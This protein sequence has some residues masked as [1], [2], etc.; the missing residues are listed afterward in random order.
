MAST[1]HTVFA[2]SAASG[3][4]LQRERAVRMS[5]SVKSCRWPDKRL[6]RIG[7][8]RMGH[9]RANPHAVQFRLHYPNA[10]FHAARVLGIRELRE[11]LAEMLVPVGHP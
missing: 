6:V 4:S 9:S 1:A 5:P 11:R 7:Q 2:K 10:Y 8:G 3:S